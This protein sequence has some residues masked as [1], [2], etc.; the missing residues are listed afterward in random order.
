MVM[1]R[2]PRRLAVREGAEGCSYAVLW[3]D[4]DSSRN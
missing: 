3:F 4:L 1:D 2:F